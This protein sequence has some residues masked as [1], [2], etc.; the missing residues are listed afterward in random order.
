MQS[1]LYLLIFALH[2][3][4]PAWFTSKDAL[5]ILEGYHESTYISFQVYIEGLF[6]KSDDKEVI[7]LSY[8]TKCLLSSVKFNKEGVV[9]F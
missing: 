1:S 6:C 8:D 4:S 9:G 5:G 7:H 2:F 3:A